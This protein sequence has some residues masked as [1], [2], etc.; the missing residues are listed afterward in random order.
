MN[1]AIDLSTIMLLV[2]TTAA[3]QEALRRTPTGTQT[4]PPGH[5]GI[6]ILSD[7]PAEGIEIAV[8]FAPF[9]E[10]HV[11]AP[12][13]NTYGQLSVSGC[14]ATA[15]GIGWPEMPFK[16]DGQSDKA[17]LYRLPLTDRGAIDYRITFP[18]MF[19]C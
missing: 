9:P 1:S 14:G 18:S 17:V 19:L 3:N 7:D 8:R 15:Q 12:G 6:T 5:A 11:I 10:R 13:G 2:L 16:D 4:V